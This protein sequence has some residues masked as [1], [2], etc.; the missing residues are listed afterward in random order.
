MS[1]TEVVERVY[2]EHRARMLAALVRILGDFELAEDALQDACTLALRRWEDT[3]PGDPV[4]W[5]LTAA[6][7]KAIDRLRRARVGQE[8]QEQTAAGTVTMTDFSEDRLV[9]VGDERLSLIFTCCHP[10]L[11]EEA[12]VALTLQAVVGLTAAQ[13]ARMFL[14]GEATLA[15]RLVRAKRK[16]RD[17]GISLEVPAD[18][19]LPERLDGVL[20]V[21]YLIF[22]QG[23]T[24]DTE[25]HTVQQ[26][27]IRL[28]KLIATLMPDEPEA[29]GLVAL[30]LLH[31]SR[32]AARYSDTGEVV[33]LADQDRARWNGA[34]IVEAVRVLGRALRHGTPGPYQV[35]A[36]IAAL[37]AQAPSAEQTDWPRIA[38]LYTEL[39][40]LAP[41]PVVALNRA[42]AVAMAT[43]PTDGLALIDRIDGLERYHL[44]HAARADLLRRLGRSGAAAAA[45]RRAHELATNPADRRYLAGRLLALDTPESR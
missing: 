28:A 43:T 13:I 33:L 11:A 10:A 19:L 14:V 27:A 25:R 17:A 12:R 44:L 24:A 16:I 37:H 9:S 21:V 3:V 4:A 35:Q 32:A 22:T 31:D 15:Q 45:Y 23:Y 40:A 30:L 1:A 29:L 18:H 41:S 36:A 34:E 39:L 20:A 7:N 2:R 8:K 42:V 6:R 38:A 26:E 5:L